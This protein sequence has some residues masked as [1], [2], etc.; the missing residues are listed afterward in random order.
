MHFFASPPPTANVPVP[1]KGRT[2]SW[3]WTLTIPERVP[4]SCSGIEIPI[5]RI[6]TEDRGCG[7]R[8]R[9]AGIC[10]AV[11]EKNVMDRCERAL[12]RVRLLNS[13][14]HDLIPKVD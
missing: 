9:D 12:C 7:N 13:S 2:G 8:V 4:P 5:L 3:P 6:R 11:Q 10:P 14:P 1:I